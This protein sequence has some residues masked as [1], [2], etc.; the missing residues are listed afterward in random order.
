MANPA[1]R[2]YQYGA[3][4]VDDVTGYR[5][6]GHLPVERPDLWRRY[7]VGAEGPQR[8][9]LDDE[10]PAARELVDG[11]GVPL[12]LVAFDDGGDLAAGLRVHGPLESHFDAAVT[13]ELASSL[14]IGDLRELIDGEL[15]LGAL[16]VR[17]LFVAPGNDRHDPLVET[18]SRCVTHAMN[19]LGAEFAVAAVV[20]SWVALLSPSGGRQVGERGALSADGRARRVA[21]SWRRARA[22]EWSTP[23]NR[24]ALRRESEELLR[25][26]I[27]DGPVALDVSVARTRSWRPLVLDASTRAQRE[28]LRVLRA[29]PSLQVIDRY[30]EQRD[31]LA[32]LTPPPGPVLTAESRRWVYYPW[33]RAVVGLLARNS[34]SA[35][36]L[37]RNH[38]K[39]TRA[40]Q[41]QLRRLRVGVVGVSAGHSIAFALAMEGL[42]GE[43]RLS[44][45]DTL[46]LSN[47]NRL[48][49][50][51]LDLGVNKAV[52]CARRI[53]EIDPYLNV[54]VDTEGVRPDTLGAFLEGLDL[55]IE[56]CDSLDTKFLVREVAR[57]MR[58]PV[59]MET[60]DS[61]VL[62]VERFD[63]EPQRQLFHGL[64]GDMDYT[65]LCGLSLEE[66]GPYIARM[67]GIR[68]ISSRA[69]A[70]VI[71]LGHTVTGWPQ[72]ASE[73]TL[74]A[75]A[76]AV[77]VRRF[78]IDGQLPSGR[79]S[80]DLEGLVS[81]LA[82]VEVN[83]ELESHLVAPPPEEIELVS[84]DPIELIVDAAR[85]A[86]S[87]GNIQPWRFE[88]DENAVRFFL[89]PERTTMMDVAHRASYVAMGA[90]LCNA[91]VRA[92][93]LSKLGPLTLFP[94]GPYSHL[95]AKLEIGSASDDALVAL[96]GA[97]SRRSVNR[98]VGQPE[99]IDE[100]TA[101]Q[102]RRDGAREG[103][104]VRLV[105]DAPSIAECAEILAE[106]DR[107]RFLTPHLHGEMMGE[108]RW[109]GRDT[110]D[111]GLD[112]RTLEVDRLGVA[113]IEALARPDVV[114]HLAQWRGGKALGQRTRSMIAT[115]SALVA[116]TTPRA[117]PA[118]YVRAGGALERLWLRAELAGL[119]VQPISPIFLYA[120]TEEE[121]SELSGSRYF[122]ELHALSSKFD[123]FWRLDEGEATAIV[124]R[125]SHAGPPSARS[126]RLPLSEVFSRNSPE[127]ELEE[128]LRDA[129]N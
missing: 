15:R 5:V 63:L 105:T 12:F 71:E 108:I 29:N 89:V 56:E 120:R 116:I 70:S 3:S 38:N 101:D 20:D 110:L 59:I 81:Q 113:L 24:V 52:L 60:S 66:K 8:R 118:G 123:A 64:L 127:E 39:I 124:L 104:R 85:R 16:E 73:V 98:R 19:W 14:E 4:F 117:D 28:T 42:V 88:A 48:P 84:D 126:I 103:A 92:A 121:L 111:E 83:D 107:L 90:A 10:G 1:G 32:Q 55:V 79:V 57:E 93:T 21:V 37:D 47:L 22:N 97:V 58:I 69:V 68:E 30:D 67:M 11:V 6:E 125:I 34:F 87:G 17:G 35:L 86:P 45:F 9:T 109:P 100:A 80:I 99:D 44:D 18:L 114:G 82:P 115:S 74:G 25:R 94:E 96:E 41:A 119:A 112:V 54:V 46:E 7:L 26:A 76:V 95:V 40:E 75:A 128:W 53:A 106:S 77:A 33:R 102:W 36:R 62:D 51:V 78:W 61:G 129:R 122:D 50:S 13:E 72:L 43:L 49:A 31:Q 23:E 2:R 91:R 27:S 65:K